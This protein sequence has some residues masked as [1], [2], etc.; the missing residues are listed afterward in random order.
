MAKEAKQCFSTHVAIQ[1]A[2]ALLPLTPKHHSLPHKAVLGL[3]PC[4]CLAGTALVLARLPLEKIAECLSELCAVQVLA[5]KKVW[6][7][8]R[9]GICPQMAV[10]LLRGHPPAWGCHGDNTTD[11]PLPPCPFST[12]ALT[13]AKQRALLRPHCAPGSPRSHLQV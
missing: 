5:L 9:A 1:T 7:W 3:D 4:L 13:G 8:H 6:P 2:L 10:T 12:A 11:P